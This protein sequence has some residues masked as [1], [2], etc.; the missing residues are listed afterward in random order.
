[1]DRGTLL[2][3]LL[4]L[5]YSQANSWRRRWRLLSAHLLSIRPNIHPFQY[6]QEL[7][8]TTLQGRRSAS[9]LIIRWAT[10]FPFC[11]TAPGEDSRHQRFYILACRVT[12]LASHVSLALF[13]DKLLLFELSITSMTDL[14][15]SLTLLTL[16]G[17]SAS[18]CT[19]KR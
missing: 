3:P 14:T 4:C 5:D 19:V 17:T 16:V 12:K 7:A 10:T 15:Y 2:L 18:G 11:F 1:M 13:F 8:P 9:H 6:R